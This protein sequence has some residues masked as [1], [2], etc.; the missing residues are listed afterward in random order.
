MTD[1]HPAQGSIDAQDVIAK[2]MTEEELL[3]NVKDAATKF[4]WLF[5]HTR[6]SRSSDAG[7][8]DVVLVRPSGADSARLVFAELKTEKGAVSPSQT[9]WLALLGWVGAGVE[10][11]TWRPSTWLSGAIHEV[12]R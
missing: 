7:F 2:T 1:R 4:G 11:Y 9:Q 6:D 10:V 12:L 5:Y 8:P 3:A